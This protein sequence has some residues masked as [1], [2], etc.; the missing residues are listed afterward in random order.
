MRQFYRSFAEKMSHLGATEGSLARRRLGL[1]ETL[2][3][4]F[5]GFCVIHANS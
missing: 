2:C 1:S 3:Y 5:E 4:D